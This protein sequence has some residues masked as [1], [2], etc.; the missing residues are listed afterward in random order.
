M[1]EFR[2]SHFASFEYKEINVCWG[3]TRAY[4][5]KVKYK[6][7]SATFFFLKVNEKKHFY[8]FIVFWYLYYILMNLVIVII[9]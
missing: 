1:A 4:S 8:G 3:P 5:G 6:K 7:A 2:K 9:S